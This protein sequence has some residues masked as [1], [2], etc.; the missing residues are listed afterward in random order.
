MIFNINYF[1]NLNLFKLSTSKPDWLHMKVA[2]Y[3]YL[4]YFNNIIKIKNH[5]DTYNELLCI[6]RY[7][8]YLHINLICLYTHIYIKNRFV[9]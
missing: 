2:I 3:L 5:Y 6:T 8:I 1:S 9:Q 7:K 4:I